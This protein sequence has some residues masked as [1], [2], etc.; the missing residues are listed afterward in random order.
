VAHEHSYGATS[1]NNK[2]ENEAVIFLLAKNPRLRRPSK[3]E[4]KKIL[5]ELG[6]DRSFSRAYDLVLIP[7]E[8]VE[9]ILAIPAEQLILVELKTTKKK[10]LS[11]PDGFFF[12]A[13]ENEFRLAGL[14]GEKYQFCFVCLH[15]ESQ[16][17]VLMSAAALEKKIKT[18]RIQYQI[19][20]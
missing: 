15:P 20:L 17:F 8:N 12:G 16:G 5:S 11:N 1:K 4:R 7:D 9:D 2:T 6:L 18:R 13:T 10:L 19:N 3:L 14:L